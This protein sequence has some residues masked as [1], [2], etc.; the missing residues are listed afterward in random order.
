MTSLCRLWRN[1]DSLYEMFPVEKNPF[2]GYIYNI[3]LAIIEFVGDF[4]IKMSDDLLDSVCAGA[5]MNYVS[6]LKFL[7]RFEEYRSRFVE[8]VEDIDPNAFPVP[9][10]TELCRYVT[11]GQAAFA[12]VL[13]A[14]TYILD[15]FTKNNGK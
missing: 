5:G 8:A 9:Q 7:D 13:E 10:W 15:K 12:S 2:F 6:D 4:M 3:V 11:G 1:T 14:K